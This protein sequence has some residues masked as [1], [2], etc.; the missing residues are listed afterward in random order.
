MNHIFDIQNFGAVNDGSTDCSAAITAACMA[1]LGCGGA[2]VV[3]PGNFRIDS[4]IVIGPVAANISIMGFGQNVSK[5]VAHSCSGLDFTFAMDGARQPW[6]LDMR[7]IGL[8]AEGACGKAI[9]ISYGD[10][11]EIQDHNN[12]GPSLTNVAI[13][14]GLGGSWDFGVI[15]RNAWNSILTNVWAVGDSCGGQWGMMEGAGLLMKGANV[16]THL[17]SCRFNFW[18]DGVLVEA[19]D[20][21]IN[22]EG[23]FL[24]NCSMVGVKRG[25]NIAGN[26]LAKTPRMSTLTVTGGL[27]EIRAGGVE[28]A[29]VSAGIFLTS[30][31]TA[32]ISGMQILAEKIDLPEGKVTYGILG[33]DC[34]GVVATCCDLNAVHHGFHIGGNS[35]ACS[36]HGCTF[37]NCKEQVVFAPSAVEGRSYGHVRF[38]NAPFEWSW[39]GGNKIG[40]EE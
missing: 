17:N 21:E 26:P 40:F 18:A 14:L 38:N 24:T 2:V 19:S 25:V 15:L 12:P 20:Q 39:G 27:I 37:T 32:L 35:K 22:S 31:W 29:D 8:V 5:I 30:V 4:P 23:L 9:R 6:T 33:M 1:A 13:S 16:N 11:L 3:P 34:A 36:A 10:V 28:A 7:D